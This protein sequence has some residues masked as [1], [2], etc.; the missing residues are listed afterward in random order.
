[1][2]DGRTLT[3][4]SNAGGVTNITTSTLAGG[5]AFNTFLSVHGRQGRVVNLFVSKAA[6]NLVN[7]VTQAP[8]DVE[9]TLIPTR[10]VR[11]AA[12]SCSPIPTE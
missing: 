8:V 12:T 3:N 1:V 5:N 4:V 2:P 7:I 11:S 6:N 9:G 10:T